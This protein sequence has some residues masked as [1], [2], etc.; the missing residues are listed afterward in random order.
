MTDAT[1]V[2]AP[3]PSHADH[4]GGDHG[5]HPTEKQYLIVAL[6]L[7]VLTAIEVALYYVEGMNET[8]LVAMLGILA[9][10]KFV[11]VILYFMHLKFDS[12][13][14]RRFFYTGVILALAIYIVV[15]A[16]FHVFGDSG[17]QNVLPG[18]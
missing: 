12:P 3:A 1:T 16:T 8:A 14:F 15:L 11:M 6:V 7:A 5:H 18:G 10:A 4:G 17:P 2:D 13:V 9:V